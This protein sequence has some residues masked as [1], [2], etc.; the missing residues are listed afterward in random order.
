MDTK[1]TKSTLYVLI[2]L[3]IYIFPSVAAATDVV[4]DLRL[5]GV[6][7]VMDPLAEKQGI[8]RRVL[9]LLPSPAVKQES[10]RYG[11][12]FL[13]PTDPRIAIASPGDPELV[14]GDLRFQ[15]PYAVIG[16]GQPLRIVNH[17][18]YPLSFT[19]QMDQ[20]I[21]QVKVPP[22]GVQSILLEG[23]EQGM[24]ICDDLPYLKAFIF[25]SRP[26]YLR[27]LPV[28]G[29]GFSRV[30]FS[31]VQPGSYQMM[32][33]SGKWWTTQVFNVSGDKTVLRIDID[34]TSPETSIKAV[35]NPPEELAP[36]QGNE[37][38][39]IED[40]PMFLPP[41]SESEIK[42]PVEGLENVKEKA[43]KEAATAAE[44]G[45]P[46]KEPKAKQPEAVPEKSKDEGKSKAGFSGFK[47]K[48]VEEKK[49]EEPKEQDQEKG[50]PQ[51]LF[52]IKRV[53][54]SK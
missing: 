34:A 43:P 8:H 46:S 47:I 45:K 39:Q 24:V 49:K 38:V 16:P 35:E 19:I 5:F 21:Q 37:S 3:F 29:R 33:W 2:S 51:P 42:A 25:R 23:T 22:K 11:F 44:K 10:R 53:E 40:R 48:K 1:M 27:P 50:E 9:P 18:T 13:K 6:E 20:K 12:L 30:V 14:V 17:S 36:A 32:I 28:L 52:K 31:G 15:T 4:G 54:E 26:G 41:S 7:S